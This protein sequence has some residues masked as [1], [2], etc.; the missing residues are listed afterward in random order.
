M[1]LAGAVFLASLFLMIESA[2]KL[3]EGLGRASISLGVTP[4]VLGYVLSGIDLDNLSVGVAGILENLPVIA[5][6]TVIGSATFLLTFAVGI[7]ALLAPIRVRTPRRLIV[8]TLLS[9]LPFSAVSLDGTVS[10]QDG[11]LLVVA[12][13]G[14]IAYV[15]RTARTHPLFVA[16]AKRVQGALESRPIGRTVGLILGAS[17]AIIVGAELFRWSAT[18]LVTSLGWDTG[19]FGMVVVAALVSFEEVPRMVVPARRGHPEISVGSILGTVLFFLLFNVG[20]IAVVR[21]IVV[22]TE[23][24]AF[25][26]PAMML[27]LIVVSA[28]LWRGGVGRAAGTLLVAGYLIYVAAAVAGGYRLLP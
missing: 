5:L 10:R 12:A 7:T 11:A 20:I 24:L 16:N 4:F 2:E 3:T 23:V 18:R 22:E 28:L 19:W 8:L 21:P 15:V 26:W 27:S 9:P 17:I 13:C 1:I 6:G 25:H 14:L